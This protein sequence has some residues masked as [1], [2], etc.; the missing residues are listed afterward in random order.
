M[1][2]FRFARRSNSHFNDVV[3]EMCVRISLGFAVSQLVFV[4]SFKLLP[5]KAVNAPESA[6]GRIT[7]RQGRGL[8]L[9][10]KKVMLRA[11]G[12][13]LPYIYST[14]GTSGELL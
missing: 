7:K 1:V 12:V 2:V 9:L 10:R 6:L 14:K 11:S 3:H 4:S 13:V 5:P 8:V